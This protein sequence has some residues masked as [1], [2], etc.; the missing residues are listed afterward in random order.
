MQLPRFG[1]DTTKKVSSP[2]TRLV[3]FLWEDIT[4]RPTQQATETFEEEV[5]RENLTPKDL[6]EIRHG[7]QRAARLFLLATI[8][9]AA[10]GLTWIFAAGIHNLMAGL[11]CASLSA[12]MAAQTIL[13]LSRAW[14]I[15]N[16]KKVSLREWLSSSGHVFED[17]F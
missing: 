3:K 11:V 6:E 12:Y 5:A 10:F 9:L 7:H 2:M 13:S 17:L 15:R 14:Q 1:L 16:R 4:H 8:G